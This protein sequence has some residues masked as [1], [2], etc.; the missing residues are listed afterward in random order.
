ALAISVSSPD[1]DYHLDILQSLAFFASMA[2]QHERSKACYEETI[3]LT[4]PRGESLHRANALMALGLDAWRMGDTVH[5][6]ELQRSGL[7]IKVGLDDQL[8]TAVGLEA[9]AWGLARWGSTSVQPTCWARQKCCGI[10]PAPRSRRCCRSSSASTITPW[11]LPA[12]RSAIR[13]MRPRFGVAGR[14]RSPR[15]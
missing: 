8:G 1:L 15:C 3:E 7:E 9:L 10:R 6:V 12:P 11:P 5:A 14:C 13:R 2:G 4:E